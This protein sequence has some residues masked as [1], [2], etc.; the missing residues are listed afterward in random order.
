METISFMKS[1]QQP[2]EYIEKFKHHEKTC[3]RCGKN[4]DKLLVFPISMTL[5][6]S[7]YPMPYCSYDNLCYRTALNV[8]SRLTRFVKCTNYEQIISIKRSSGVIEKN[9]WFVI[10]M[11]LESSIVLC[12]HIK[13]KM[14][15]CLS[16]DELIEYNDD[17]KFDI[18]MF[19]ITERLEII[20]QY[21][22]NFRIPRR[23]VHEIFYT[24]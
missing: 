10:G 18:S 12:G 7:V 2:I 9:Q 6:I 8:L 1:K 13:G 5:D 4:C 21:I 24:D 17:L 22:H 14:S 20:D 11:E 23:I 19:P 3:I 16:L 15:K